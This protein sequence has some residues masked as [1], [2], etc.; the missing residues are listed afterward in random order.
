[1]ASTAIIATIVLARV[2]G[3]A[4]LGELNAK[5]TTL[6]IV[7]VHLIE[8]MIIKRMSRRDLVTYLLS[9][10]LGIGLFDKSDERKTT[11]VLGIMV[12]T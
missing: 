11:A 3:P 10:F 8:I 12:P 6:E 2:F 1:M 4:T 7:A 5:F 9:S